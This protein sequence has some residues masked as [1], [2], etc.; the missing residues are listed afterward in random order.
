MAK[1]DKK[2]ST[3]S[4]KTQKNRHVPQDDNG[5]LDREVCIIH[6]IAA[7]LTEVE[8][9]SYMKSRGHKMERATY[10]HEKKKIEQRREKIGH[11]LAAGG[12]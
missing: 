2:S 8:S 6:C 4:K 11:K 9:L 1:A 3:A 10:Y 5:K 12:L 7:K